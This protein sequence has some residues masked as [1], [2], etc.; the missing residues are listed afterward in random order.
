[1]FT[2]RWRWE[3]GRQTINKEIKDFRK[4]CQWAC[5]L[6]FRLLPPHDLVL[7]WV[8][9]CGQGEPFSWDSMSM[10]H[11]LCNAV[12]GLI[13]WPLCNERS[14]NLPFQAA[15]CS[16]S[17]P[18]TYCCVPRTFAR[19]AINLFP[20]EQKIYTGCYFRA[21]DSAMDT[22]FCCHRAYVLVRRHWWLP[23][24]QCQEETAG[25]EVT[26]FIEWSRNW[27][28]STGCI[29]KLIY[30]SLSLT[31]W[32]YLGIHSLLGI[33][34][35]VSLWDTVRDSSPSGWLLSPP[36]VLLKER[37][38]VLA[39]EYWREKGIK[40]PRRGWSFLQFSL[41][42]SF[43]SHQSQDLNCSWPSKI[44]LPQPLGYVTGSWHYS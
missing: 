1:M 19:G 24:Q 40:Y 11:G 3:R 21:V 2:F 34:F 35:G 32:W 43:L 33:Q 8:T 18:P 4:K 20:Q 44:W 17:F 25:Q 16:T 42:S 6:A 27:P 5:L 14:N 36:I 26:L 41:F 7:L 37:V 23:N 10:T 22:L 30:R 9:F 29:L 13:G 12:C 39:T 38:C 28:M 15:T 31:R